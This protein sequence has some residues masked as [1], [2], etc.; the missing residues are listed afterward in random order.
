MT[1][2]VEWARWVPTEVRAALA[3]PLRRHL[4]LVPTWVHEIVVEWDESPEGDDPPALQALGDPEYRQANLVVC[5]AFLGESPEV[6]DREVLHEIVHL[7]LEPL[8]ALARTYAKAAADA[9]E[10]SVA[11]KVAEEHIRTAVEGGVCD[12]TSALARR[13]G[14][15]PLKKG[16][17]QKA[18][19]SN[20][21]KLKK[22]GY[23]QDQAVA[24]SL[25]KAGKSKRRGGRGK[26]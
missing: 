16:K 14:G 21:K 13:E 4:W 1:P 8:R 11:F 26:K 18:V 20:I 12:L 15:M 10:E 2:R 9:D 22:E 5:P 19:S 23:K 25:K 7:S 6:R 3:P 17:S 24:I